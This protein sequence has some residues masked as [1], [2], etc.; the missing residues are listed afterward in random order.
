MLLQ[1]NPTG[2]LVDIS[3]ELTPYNYN[4]AVYIFG[5][6]YP[7]FPAFSWHLLFLNMFDGPES[8][9]LLAF[10]D[11]QYFACSDNGFLPMVFN[12]MPEKV[13][14]LVQPP[15]TRYQVMPWIRRVADAI[16]QIEAGIA[17][18][19]LGPEVDNL[20][21]KNSLKPVFY[22][23]SI[24][25]RII[26]IDRFENVV[27][28]ITR[29]EFDAACKS[30]SFKLTFKGDESISKLSEGYGQVPEGHKLAFFNAAGYLEIAVN[31]GNAAGLFG[32][33]AFNEKNNPQLLQTRMFYHTVRIDFFEA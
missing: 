3:H 1:A 24:E 27:V 33:Q 9:I 7:C 16:A 21:V 28:N 26:F 5:N 29:H 15:E 8:R 19:E 31:K 13:I 2:T 17:F 30:R 11:N 14:E 20:V 10:H 23:D 6:S 18:Q 25:G 32:L 22:P 4:E 12:G